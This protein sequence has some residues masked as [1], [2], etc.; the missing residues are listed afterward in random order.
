MTGR[1]RELPPSFFALFDLEPRFALP[2]EQLDA[3]YRTLARRVHPDRFVNGTEAEQ[4]QAIET[5]THVNE[6]YRTLRTPMLRARH[7]LDLRGIQVGGQGGA[8]SQAFL[9]AQFEWRATLGEARASRDEAALRALDASAREKA[10][11][12]NRQLAVQLDSA[13]NDAGAVE[14]VLQLMFLDRLLADVGDA[15]EALEA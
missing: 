14:S 3:A 10:D 11:E 15:R 6:G 9:S 1:G 4:R 5:A 13:R 7:L 2:I 12:L 8:T